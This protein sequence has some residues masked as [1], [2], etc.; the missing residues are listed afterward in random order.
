MNDNEATTILQTV[1]SHVNASNTKNNASKLLRIIKAIE[2]CDNERRNM[3]KSNSLTL[4][5]SSP[6]A[7]T[8][9][10]GQITQFTPHAGKTNNDDNDNN[11]DNKITADTQQTPTSHSGK[12][13]L[14]PSSSL[15]REQS[16]SIQGYLK[17]QK[18]LF[19]AQLSMRS[20]SFKSAHSLLHEENANNDN[21]N[22]ENTNII[23]NNNNINDNKDDVET[24]KPDLTIV[25]PL[26]KA[27]SHSNVSNDSDD[28][29]NKKKATQKKKRR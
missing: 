18:K 19:H 21:D 9:G 8:S 16:E 15:V 25:P 24:D 23:D 29:N 12:L 26:S 22:N 14:E 7:A 4:S 11:N 5:N 28:E 1:C 6:M 20:L 10:T 2:Y 3:L 27:P 13:V 17:E